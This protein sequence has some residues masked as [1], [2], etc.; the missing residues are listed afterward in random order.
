MLCFIVGLLT[1]FFGILAYIYDESV[2]GYIIRRHPYRDYAFPLVVLGIVFIA[3]SLVIEWYG[4]E[5]RRKE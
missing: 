3:I 5:D 1:L 2:G 4:K